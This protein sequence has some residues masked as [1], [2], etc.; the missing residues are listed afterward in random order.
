VDLAFRT[1]PSLSGPDNAVAS[2]LTMLLALQ[3]VGVVV[4]ESSHRDLER[5]RAVDLAPLIGTVR[6]FGGQ[7]S[8]A[9]F[10]P[11]HAVDAV[12]L[13]ARCTRVGVHPATPD[14]VASW[15]NEAAVDPDFQMPLPREHGTLLAAVSTSLAAVWFKPFEPPEHT[16]PFHDDAG[17]LLGEVPVFGGE[18]F[19]DLYAENEL[20]QLVGM[21]LL[22]VGTAPDPIDPPSRGPVLLFALPRP[23]TALAQVER[24]LSPE[25]WRSWMTGFEDATVRLTVPR[26]RLRG[27][28][29]NR[30]ALE[31]LD[32]P[33][34]VDA[35]LLDSLGTEAEIATAAADTEASVDEQG[36]S[37][38]DS[39][40]LE[41]VIRSDRREVDLTRPFLVFVLERSSGALLLMGRVRRPEG[42]SMPEGS[43]GEYE[44]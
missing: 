26:F 28:S 15:R 7:A 10:V 3:A 27:E 4:E 8:T 36:L 34:T 2:P 39:V 14:A 29:L 32:L 13:A 42:L 6:D 17:Q 41:I 30:T 11:E 35:E 5:A 38:Q 9:L 12:R 18:R 33:S 25:L 16:A 22:P 19:T 43:A 40:A 20:V 1:W 24:R 44:P 21:P 37:V 31:A 23:G